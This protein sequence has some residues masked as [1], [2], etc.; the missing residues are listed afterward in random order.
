[1]ML[2]SITQEQIDSY[3][4]RSR[5]YKSKTY[6][7]FED[8]VKQK[9]PILYTQLYNNDRENYCH[10]IQD[11]GLEIPEELFPIL[12]EYSKTVEALSAGI[13][14]VQAKVK[15]NLMTV[16]VHTQNALTQEQR[17]IFNAATEKMN[18]EANIILQ[19]DNE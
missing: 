11:R 5:S 2:I 1:M 18:T 17:H 19:G 6:L 3:I 16:Y 12:E 8:S 9:Y 15:F 10:P 14:I 4:A 7:T 13:Q